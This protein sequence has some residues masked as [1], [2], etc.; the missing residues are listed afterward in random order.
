MASLARS[1]AAKAAALCSHLRQRRI[2]QKLVG[3]HGPASHRAAHW[4][5]RRSQEIRFEVLVHELGGLAALADATVLDVGCGCGDFAAFLDRAGAQPRELVG[6][7]IVPA[8]I[9]ACARRWAAGDSAHT[10]FPRRFE[11]CDLL[12]SPSWPMAHGPFDYVVSSGVFAF[13]DNTAPQPL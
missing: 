13:G 2:Y 11:C 7:D 8:A 3:E 4:N 10:A 9:S 12:L 6:I 5:S 1:L